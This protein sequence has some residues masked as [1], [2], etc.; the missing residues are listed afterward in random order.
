MVMMMVMQGRSSRG[1]EYYL[2]DEEHKKKRQKRSKHVWRIRDRAQEK[3]NGT[4]PFQWLLRLGKTNGSHFTWA[5][6]GVGSLLMQ[7]RLLPLIRPPMSPCA[8]FLFISCGKRHQFRKIGVRQQSFRGFRGFGWDHVKLIN[9]NVFIF[10]KFLQK[11][12]EEE[13]ACRQ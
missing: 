13:E 11:T 10:F 9:V 12:E 2:E 5:Y 3:S 1:L 8:M 6:D 7:T 4:H